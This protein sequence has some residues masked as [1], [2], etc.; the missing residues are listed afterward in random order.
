MSTIHGSVGEERSPSPG[1]R[2]RLA[3]VLTAEETSRELRRE[4]NCDV[5]RGLFA[6]LRAK[7]MPGEEANLLA[8]E[9]SQG[10]DNAE[11]KLDGP[12]A[13]AS[14]VV[15][16]LY[17]RMRRL[18]MDEEDAKKRAIKVS[19]EVEHAKGSLS[20]VLPSF[21][22]Q[23]QPAL[24]R[25]RRRFEGV[26]KPI[27]LPWPSLAAHFGGGLWPGLHFLTSGTG[28]G[29]TAFVLQVCL[30]AARLGIPVA[31]IGLELEAFQTVLRVLADQAGV[32]WSPL[33]TGQSD[34]RSTLA[35]ARAGEDLR[36]LDP[37][38][39]LHLFAARPQGWAPS[40]VE[41]IGETIRESYPEMYG[42]GSRPILMV[43]DY[44]QIIG[45]EQEH[46]ADIRERIGRASYTMRWLAS[47]VNTAVLAVSSV[48]REKYTTLATAAKV[49]GV[50][51]SKD[52][53]GR[54][55]ER[56][57]LNPDGV[58]GLGKE[59]GEIEYSADSVSAL[60][61]LPSASASYDVLFLTAKGRATGAMW[62]PLHFSG[63]DYTE[64]HDG[65]GAVVAVLEGQAAEKE[66]AREDKRQAVEKEKEEERAR[67]EEQKRSA[68]AEDLRQLKV[69]IA[70]IIADAPG[71]GTVRLRAQV[72]GAKGRVADARV[73]DAVASLVGEGVVKEEK[74]KH[75][76]VAKM[77]TATSAIEMVDELPAPSWRGGE[78]SPLKPYGSA[79]GTPPPTAPMAS[80]AN[81]ADAASTTSATEEVAEA[82]S[83]PGAEGETVAG[84]TWGTPHPDFPDL[85]TVGAAI[86]PAAPEGVNGV[87][88]SSE[89][90]R[91]RQTSWTK[92][93][94]L[95]KLGADAATEAVLLARVMAGRKENLANVQ[96]NRTEEK[97]AE[98][99]KDEHPF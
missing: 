87:I 85:P 47:D 7:G 23:V 86:A 74:G 89:V 51:Y 25:V 54:P 22:E 11:V 34:E 70:Q 91:G 50:T 45:D 99:P 63:F 26:E 82:S 19:L 39:P 3:A 40:D 69:T 15:S 78:S 36:G 68:H 64:P 72:R 17:W 65:G 90:P 97:N 93:A 95:T 76:P 28:V 67:R 6:L 31:Y 58:V 29:K 21:S 9:A 66:Q 92:P 61:R 30:H 5:F 43:L 37:P 13:E 35:L 88:K 8:E 33:Y 49:A 55:V 62:S 81:M 46:R 96:A 80:V 38:L 10:R 1:W 16:V 75:F 59:S 12:V 98:A 4:R 42:V 56:F 52:A 2:E 71:I 77:A 44:L 94:E 60:C 84:G 53:E 79:L 83:L 14:D 41:R 32:R 57:M 48:A 24:D 27:P 20:I 73:T 18:G